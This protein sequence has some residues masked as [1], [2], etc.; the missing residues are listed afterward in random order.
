M[1]A[2]ATGPSPPDEP[3]PSGPQTR[4]PASAAL[5]PPPRRFCEGLWVTQHQ[6]KS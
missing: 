4:G 1:W 6:W 5:P 3:S 2:R